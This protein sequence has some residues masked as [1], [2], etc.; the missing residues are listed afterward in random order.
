MPLRLVGALRQAE[1]IPGRDSLYENTPWKAG[2]SG[3][4]VD[5]VVE[6]LVAVEAALGGAGGVGGVQGRR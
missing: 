1:P 3:G 5:G 2:G 6:D 4:A